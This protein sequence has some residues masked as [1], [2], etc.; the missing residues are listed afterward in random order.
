M[1]SIN[2]NKTSHS[3][4][5][6]RLEWVLGNEHQITEGLG[7]S[8][9]RKK[10]ATQTPPAPQLTWMPRPAPG[11]MGISVEDCFHCRLI[12]SLLWKLKITTLIDYYF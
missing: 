10:G 2:S 7:L 8:M 1:H 6:K 5:G 11:L 9:S 4:K 12:T 3:R